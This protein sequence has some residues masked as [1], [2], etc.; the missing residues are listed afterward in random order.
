MKGIYEETQ[1]AAIKRVLTRQIE[2]AMK[3][4]K[5]AKGD[6]ARRDENQP[7]RSLNG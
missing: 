4:R 3:E 5:I 1:A 6:M 2:H 7:C